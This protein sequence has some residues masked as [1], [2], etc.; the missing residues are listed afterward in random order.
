MVMANLMQSE[1]T[2]PRE[3]EL[4]EDMIMDAM[5]YIHGKGSQEIVKALQS[6]TDTAATM[7]A[8]AYKV[9]K[10]VADK[11]A[12][13][14][15]V[16]MDMDMLMGVATE[17]IDMVTEVA[18]A[19]DQIQPGS[20]ST[21]L[22]EDTLLRLTMLHGEQLEGEEGFSAEMKESAAK[23]MRDY[24]SDG[25][26]QKAFDYINPRAKDEGLNPQDMMR[27]G[28]E[29]ALGSKNPLSDAITE[30]LKPTDGLPPPEP[31]GL[32]DTPP[33][34]DQGPPPQMGAQPDQG[35]MGGPPQAPNQ[36][37]T[38]PGIAPPQGQPPPPQ[39]PNAELAPP[40][41]RRY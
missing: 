30:G 15:H 26:T 8:V 11:R 19:A 21:R 4:V 16:E 17:A 12:K 10:G 9:V 6:S 5:E 36:L 24:M 7:A 34:S 29:A 25:G 37:P 23:D 32:M 31:A 18:Q 20:N 28:N 13:E 39:D 3:A 27:S 38:G 33:G 1:K 41:E 22:K 2:D 14:A 40:P 35:L